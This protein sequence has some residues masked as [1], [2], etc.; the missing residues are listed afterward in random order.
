MNI[1][2]N[3]VLH[4]LKTEMTFDGVR[5]RWQ[6]WLHS[7]LIVLK[8]YSARR[9]FQPFQHS[10]SFRTKVVLSWVNMMILMIHWWKTKIAYFSHV[11][12]TLLI[13]FG[14]KELTAVIIFKRDSCLFIGVVARRGTARL[15]PWCHWFCL[16][17]FGGSIWG[18]LSLPVY[19][20]TPI[21]N[22]FWGWDC[23]GTTWF[24]PF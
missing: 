9:H 1:C 6:G 18:W 3:I 13:S 14:C 12:M 11:L 23:D 16:A 7:T 24:L 22:R 15:R 19:W 17:I 20:S 5:F 4:V 8:H 10:L 2:I 21:S